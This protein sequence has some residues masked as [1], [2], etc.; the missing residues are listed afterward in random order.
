MNLYE[1][2]Q[3][4][5]D[6]TEHQL[7]K[8]YH[9]LCVKYH[10]DKGNELDSTKF[11]EIQH[12]Y[13]I[14]SDPIKRKQYDIQ[15]NLPFLNSVELSDEE[16]RLLEHYYTQLT[17]TNEYKLLS[18]LYRSIPKHIIESLKQKLQPKK[19]NNKKEIEVSAKWIYIQDMIHSQT[20]HMYVSMEDSYENKIKRV[21]IQTVYG[22]VYLFLRDFNQTITIDN[23][24]CFLTIHLHTKNGNHC[25]R[26]NDDLYYLV[27]SNKLFHII[28]LPNKKQFI[29]KLSVIHSLGFINKKSERGN[30]HIV[31]IIQ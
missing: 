23:H 9:E 14:L 22:I 15:R 27:P 12:A 2:F 20:I 30:L 3:I 7:K 17:Q 29:T 16:Y 18:L 21:Y 11:L 4:S 10:P 19:N 24:E 13:E 26:K 25:Y 6:F 8:R 5:E 28:Q 31:K 1:L